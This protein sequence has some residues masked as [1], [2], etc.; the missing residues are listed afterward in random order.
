MV[1][2]IKK[3]NGKVYLIREHDSYGRH[4][5]KMF[6]GNEYVEEETPKIEEEETPKKKGNKKIEIEK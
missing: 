3:E 1:Q 4:I 6:L 2:Y 5:D